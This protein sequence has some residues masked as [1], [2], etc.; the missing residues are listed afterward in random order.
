MKREIYLFFIVF[1]TFWLAGCSDNGGETPNYPKGEI[2]LTVEQEAINQKA[3]QFAWYLFQDVYKK[4]ASKDGNILI[5]PLSL[6]CAMS[7]LSNGAANKTLNEI[8]VAMQFDGQKMEQINEFYRLL[9]DEMGDVDRSVILKNANSLWYKQSIPVLDD[10]IVTNKKYYDADVRAEDFNDSKT[11]DLINK[12]CS[13]NTDGKIDKIIDNID[14]EMMYYLI[15]AIYFKGK[16]KQQFSKKDTKT[17]VF[18]L[19][20]KT[21]VQTQF[22]NR[23]IDNSPYFENDVF[24][25]SALDFG[26]GAYQMFFVLPKENIEM[27]DVVNHL[28]DT[29]LKFRS[30][31]YSVQYM[32][33]KFETAYEIDLIPVLSDLG[34]TNVFRSGA[35]FSKLSEIKSF[36]SIV[37]QK[38][39]LKIDEE[40]GEAAGVT[41]VGGEFAAGPSETVLFKLDRPF[42]YGI[43]ETSTGTILFLGHLANPTETD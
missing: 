38:T 39:Y 7:M 29:E 11:V 14:K 3:Q 9:K 24:S 42:L 27:G 1:I 6:N 30:T 40:G 13:E 32:L 22:M 43:R 10:F 21:T 33:P 37:L 2:E 8:L 28:A 36:V 26:N 31:G 19:A 16:W 25:Y 41:V 12:W 4:K 15:N 35:D 20:D 5:S 18:T 17:G 23:E 34:M